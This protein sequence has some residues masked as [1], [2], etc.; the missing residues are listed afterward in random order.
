[1]ILSVNNLA[2]D[3]N[4]IRMNRK[5]IHEYADPRTGLARKRIHTGLNCDDAPVRRGYDRAR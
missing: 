1:M 3:R 4:P 5:N 2:V